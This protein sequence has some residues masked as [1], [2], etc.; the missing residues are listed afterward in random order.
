MRIELKDDNK[1][2]SEET[3]VVEEPVKFKD[4]DRKKKAEF[5][6]DYYK[7]WIIGGLIAIVLLCTFISDYRENSKPTY[8]YVEMLNSNFGFD[9]T[10]T[11]YDD[12]VREEGIDLSKEHLTIGTEA[13]LSVDNFDTTMI[14]FQQR[15]VANYASG[16]LDVVIGPKEI[17]EGPANW[18][19]YANFDQIVPKDLMDEL[20]DREYDFYVF[21]PSKDEIEES[22]GEDVSPYIAGIYLDNCSYLND[23]GEYGAYPVAQSEGE[24]PVLAISANSKR[25]DH[26]IEFVRFLIHNR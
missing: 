4:L 9:N 1:I 12:F 8:L 11:L 22:E 15:L 26:A 16:D 17:I 2:E 20:R 24:R 3:K 14:A 25:I 21:D 10:N 18:D 13:S 6:W 19:C 7:F 5:I 23:Q